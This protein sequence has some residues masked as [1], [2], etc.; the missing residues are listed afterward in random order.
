MTTSKSPW[1]GTPWDTRVAPVVAAVEPHTAPETAER[2]ARCARELGT[3]VAFVSVRPHQPT[4]P[5]RDGDEQ[6]LSRDLLLGRKALDTA[7][8]AAARHGV[9]AYGEIVEGDPAPQIVEFAASRNAPVLVVG[10]RRET[11]GP[12]VSREVVALSAG[13]V[14]VVDRA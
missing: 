13:P 1:G 8:A 7:L 2:A 9:M 4:V 11:S 10:R 3:P 12:S 5:R 6:R 14:V